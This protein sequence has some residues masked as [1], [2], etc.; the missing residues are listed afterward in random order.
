MYISENTF[1]THDKVY[2]RTPRR[3]SL[4]DSALA[5]IPTQEN[6]DPAHNCS[7]SGCDSDAANASRSMASHGKKGC[8]ASDFHPHFPG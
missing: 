3:H 8:L 4:V 6:L 7:N 1:V 2:K 5:R